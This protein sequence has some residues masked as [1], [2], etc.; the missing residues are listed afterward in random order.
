MSAALLARRP[1]GVL[2]S[3]SQVCAR[4]IHSS[5]VGAAL[6]ARTSKLLMILCPALLRCEIYALLL[7]LSTSQS[8]SRN[9]PDKIALE[10][11][12]ENHQRGDID[13]RAGQQQVVLR[14][15]RSFEVGQ[16][17]G[18]GVVFLM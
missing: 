18:Q 16:A 5:T 14:I 1:V 15:M 2:S 11:E 4:P 12:E 7:S 9:A 6:G 17:N 10:E 8:G 13:G 3:S